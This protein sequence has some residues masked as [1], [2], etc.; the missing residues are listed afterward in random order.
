VRQWNYVGKEIE[1]SGKKAEVKMGWGKLIILHLVPGA[2]V[3]L[4]YAVLGAL[5]HKNGLPSILGF[6]AA[7]VLVLF[8]FEIGVPLFLERRKSRPVR[9]REVFQFREEVPVWQMV[10]LIG[11]SVLWAGLVFVVSGSAL[12]DPIKEALLSWVPEWYDLGHYLVSQE[13]S[14]S[15]RIV[16]WGL[17]IVFAVILGPTVEEL[18]FRGYL[19]P[20]M[21]TRRGWAPLV[22]IVLFA[23]YHFWSP[24]LVAVR[25]VAMLPMVYAVWWKR[26]I[27]I[28]IIAHCLVNL[29]GDTLSAIPL[30]FG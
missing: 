14:R 27:W 21:P 19:L 17:G 16:T 28:G 15:V 23:S 2:L 12:V 11:G 30:V 20:R 24:W 29:A 26:N 6:Y 13:Y 1:M 3:A 4:A 22:G 18:Y 25:I 5:F 8:P 9:S 7:S 10:L